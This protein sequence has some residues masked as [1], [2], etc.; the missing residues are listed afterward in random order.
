VLLR[1]AL[2]IAFPALCSQFIVLLLGTS[3]VSLIGAEELTAVANSIQSR[4]FRSFEIYVAVLLIYLAVS[5]A[6]RALLHGV[7]RRYIYAHLQRITR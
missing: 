7:S 3:V 6:V 5:L 2:V 4:S 1:P